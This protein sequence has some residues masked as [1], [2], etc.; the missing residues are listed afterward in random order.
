MN[1]QP[2]PFTPFQI[3]P[4]PPASEAPKE[5]KKRGARKVRVAKGA[6]QREPEVPGERG[7]ATPAK[8]PRKPRGPSLAARISKM[9]PD[10]LINAFASLSPS[11]SQLFGAIVR[12]LT[13]SGKKSR[14]RIVAALGKVFG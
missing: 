4:T 14:A 13:K 5:R 7:M 12:E 6:K 1:D 11:D 8:K 2:S 3:P 9:D 10:L